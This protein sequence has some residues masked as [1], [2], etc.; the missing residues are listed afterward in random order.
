MICQQLGTC[1]MIYNTLCLCIEELDGCTYSPGTIDAASSPKCSQMI[2][3][4]IYSEISAPERKL[5]ERTDPVT[6]MSLKEEPLS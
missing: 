1:K 5:K 6:M 2:G 4:V 3:I